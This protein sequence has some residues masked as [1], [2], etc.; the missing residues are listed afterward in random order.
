MNE[1]HLDIDFFRKLASVSEVGLLTTVIK[2]RVKP[3]PSGRGRK[4]R[5][6]IENVAATDDLFHK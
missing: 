5:S 6:D 1:S 4:A 3:R 2:M